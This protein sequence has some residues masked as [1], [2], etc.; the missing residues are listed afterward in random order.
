M[1]EVMGRVT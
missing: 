1:E